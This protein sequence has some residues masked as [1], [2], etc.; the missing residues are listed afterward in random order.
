MN[1]SLPCAVLFLFTLLHISC[2]SDSKGYPV[3]VSSNFEVIKIDTSAKPV[4]LS[5]FASSIEYTFLETPG[6]ARIGK[7]DKLEVFSN[8]LLILDGTMSKSVFSFDRQGR[9]LFQ[10]KAGRGEMIKSDNISDFYIDKKDN[11]LYVLCGENKSI[12]VYSLPNGE[13][14]KKI[15]IKGFF[16]KIAA[17]NSNTILL[18]RDGLTKYDDYYGEYRVCQVDSMGKLVGK[19]ID[20]PMTINFNSGSIVCTNSDERLMISRMFNDTLYV[21]ENGKIDAAYKID[22]GAPMITSE[23]REV[24]DFNSFKKLMASPYIFYVQNTSFYNNKKYF[25]FYLKSGETYCHFYYDKVAKEGKLSNYI[26][27]DIDGIT[28][29]FL[30]Y[31]NDSLFVSSIDPYILKQQYNYMSASIDFDSKYKKLIEINKQMNIGGNPI[32]AFI[33]LK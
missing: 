1:F 19:W 24:K 2:S 8:N 16:K 21:F 25:S 18:L 27:N 4:A 30:H 20:T 6:E 17:K 29:P 12:F 15:K 3:E 26:K 31:M 13:L 9:L 33:K 5:E 10:K 23:F 14:I 32:I 11:L 28:I 22:L 7:I